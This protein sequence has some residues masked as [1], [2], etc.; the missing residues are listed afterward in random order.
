GE[1][2]TF[3]VYLP[4]LEALETLAVTVPADV[5]ALRKGRILLMDD[6]DIV[7]NIAGVMIRSLGHEVELV[8]NGKDAI[9][10]YRES[11]RSGR[12]FDIVIMDLTIRGGMG[13]EEAIK[14]LLEI[15]PDIKAIVS[16]GYTES[17]AISEYGALGFKACLTKPY[18][19]VSLNGTLNSLLD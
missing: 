5:R 6:E 16:S 13:G 3:F 11:M 17:S 1:G 12:Q 14:V 18:D 7:R 4:A 15:D 10:K 8:E 19:I 9:D 2:T